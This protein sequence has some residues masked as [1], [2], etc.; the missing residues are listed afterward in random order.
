[1]SVPLDTQESI[2][3]LFG[4]VGVWLGYPLAD[5]IV[6]LSITVAVF[7]IVWDSATAV[8]TQPLDGVDPEVTDEIKHAVNRT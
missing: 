1:M 2:V 6:G 3:V 8:F 5:S 4:A 7:R